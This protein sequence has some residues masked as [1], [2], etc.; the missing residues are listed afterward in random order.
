[1]R[2]NINLATQ[3]YE[4]VRSFATRWGVLL[5]L[6]ILATAGALYMT[7]TGWRNTQEYAR[8]ISHEKLEMARMDREI[9]G[10]QSILNQPA[11]KQVREQSAFLNELIARKAF[12]WTRVFSDLERLIPPKLHVISITPELDE[13][14]QLEIKMTVAG[15]SRD[16]VI[17]LLHRMEASKEFKSPMLAA[18]STEQSANKGLQFQITA[19]YVPVNAQAQVEG[20]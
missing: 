2:A 13:Q 18:E 20:D 17:E 16:R 19:V 3:P 11:N 10:A 14:N 15:D 9:A 4:D 8:G 6:L 5:A 7:Y 12:S 1:M